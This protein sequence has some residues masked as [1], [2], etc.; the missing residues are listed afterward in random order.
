MQRYDV[1]HI[2]SDQFRF[3][4]RLVEDGTVEATITIRRLRPFLPDHASGD[5]EP[6][7]QDTVG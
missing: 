7:P 1:R 2:D 3:L 5:S 4:K 6:P